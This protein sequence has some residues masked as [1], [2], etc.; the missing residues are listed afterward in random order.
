MEGRLSGGRNSD[1]TNPDQPIVGLHA[2]AQERR[3]RKAR[4]RTQL[5]PARLL[6]ACH[7]PATPAPPTA[8]P[9]PH[10]LP[11]ALPM[12]LTAHPCTAPALVA[13]GALDGGAPGGMDPTGGPGQFVST[14]SWSHTGSHL[15]VANSVGTIKVLQLA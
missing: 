2:R 3:V 14:V 4:A 10:P 6:P 11:Q 5:L 12:P 7:P 8:H 9:G 1:R 13:A 15:L